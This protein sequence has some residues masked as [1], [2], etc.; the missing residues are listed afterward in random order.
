MVLS[1]GSK[2]GALAVADFGNNEK[3]LYY[4]AFYLEPYA[5]PFT[6]TR[7]ETAFY[8]PSDLGKT[9]KVKLYFF[10]PPRIDPFFIDD[11]KIDFLSLKEDKIYSKIDGVL[12]PTK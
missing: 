6:W 7:I 2:N 11:L 5:I 3:S 8:V 10:V 12:I 4:K 9:G 1:L